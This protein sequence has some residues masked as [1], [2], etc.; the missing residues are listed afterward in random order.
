MARNKENLHLYQ[1]KLNKKVSHQK[2]ESDSDHSGI[3]YSKNTT[4][5]K[6]KEVLRRIVNEVVPSRFSVSNSKKTSL[7]L[8]KEKKTLE[9]IE[10]K[11]EEVAEEKLVLEDSIKML[12]DRIGKE[13][14]LL[15]LAEQR[16]TKLKQ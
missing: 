9:T 7:S 13:R 14:S 8:E 1:T 16:G 2:T 6:G 15:N 10:Q 4:N 11:K 5:S 12:Q 3:V